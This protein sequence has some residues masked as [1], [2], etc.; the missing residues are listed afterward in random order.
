MQKSGVDL[1]AG[2]RLGAFVGDKCPAMCQGRAASGVEVCTSR[3]GQLRW[4]EHALMQRTGSGIRARVK[5]QE[6][7]G[8]SLGGR[9]SIVSSTRLLMLSA[10]FSNNQ[11]CAAT[12]IWYCSRI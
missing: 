4:M 5:S 2:V 10:S 9:G 1:S 12:S 11:P 8:Q 7:S 3:I 6:N